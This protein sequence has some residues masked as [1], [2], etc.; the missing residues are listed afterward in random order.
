VSIHTANLKQKLHYEAHPEE[1]PH[2]RA[3]L[4]ALPS[5]A[6]EVWVAHYKEFFTA[7]NM[8]FK[9]FFGSPQRAT[10]ADRHLYLRPQV[11]ELN[12]YL[13]TLDASDPMVS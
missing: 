5:N 7:T 6:I 12:Q 3:N 1:T 9:I 2:Y 10:A 13:S 8:T 11:N 4:I